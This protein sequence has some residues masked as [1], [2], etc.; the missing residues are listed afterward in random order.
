MREAREEWQRLD[1]AESGDGAAETAGLT[2]RFYAACQRAL[3]PAQKYFEKRDAVRD[4]HRVQL[5]ALLSRVD[6][7]A[8]DASDWKAMVS[9]RHD[10]SGE[11][12]ALDRFSPRDRTALA[13]RIKQAIAALAPRIDAHTNAVKAAKDRLIAQAGALSEKADRNSIRTV[14]ELQQQWT[15]LGDGLRGVDQKQWRD[16]R[17]ACD[18]VFAGLDAD[19]K[20]RE[21]QSAALTGQ[22]QAVVDD[23]EALVRETDVETETLKTRRREL[24]LRWRDVASNDRSLDQRWRKAIDALAAR[25]AG[26]EREKRLA[27]YSLALQKYAF[28]RELE[29]S[30]SALDTLAARWDSHPELIGTFAQPLDRRWD[31]ARA[32]TV[33]PADPDTIEA[34]R[35]ALVRMEF[36]TGI[37]S[38]GD[39]RQRRMD[40]QVARLSARMRGTAQ[41]S[42]ADS[43]L[44]EML[45]IWF[46]LPGPLPEELEQ[47]FDGAARAALNALP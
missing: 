24:E 46:A 29:H 4:A 11:L 23:I 20:E 12:R 33:D 9:L 34:A 40:Y 2:R 39:D 45:S 10:L 25:S 3:K 37:S 22:A 41:A 13:K 32:G 7:L 28:L 21:A 1:A 15:A 8:T 42:D 27:R 44:V 5:D 31:R 16:F 38:P 6:A 36:S 19:R 35:D 43:E 47:R 18:R 14:R 17:A 26:R 30:T